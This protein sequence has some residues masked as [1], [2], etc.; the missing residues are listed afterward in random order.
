M[1]DIKKIYDL[2]VVGAGTGGSTAARVATQKGLEV[3]LIDRKVKN[4]I[5]NKICGDAVGTE[6]F[7]FL[8]IKHPTNEELSCHIKGAKVYSPNMEKCINLLDPKQAGYIVNRLEFGQRLL[9]EALNAGVTS[10]L[11]NTITLDLLY[12]KN[13][14]S[15]VKVKLKNGYKILL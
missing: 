5:G 2:I 15:G 14:V 4:E 11:D 6:I 12:E 10:F 3:C 7:D 9:D 13:I 1:E 8:N